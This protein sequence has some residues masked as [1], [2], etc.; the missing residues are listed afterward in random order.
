MSDIRTIRKRG[1]LIAIL[2]FL[3]GMV[4]VAR[5][6]QVQIIQHNRYAAYA[7]SQQKS[8]I[9]LKAKRGSIYDSQGKILAYDLESSTYT[10]SP[11]Y[12]SD[13]SRAARKLAKLTGKS[14]S[15]WL[16]EFE[17]H[18]GYLVVASKVSRGREAEFESA[19]IETLRRR[20]ETVRIYPYDGL[21]AEVIGRT[22]IDGVGVSGLEKYYDDLLS[23]EDGRSVYLRDAQGNEV[24]SWEH[25]IVDPMDGYD[26]HLS[27]DIDFQQIVTDEL[28]TMLD[29][30]GA[31]WGCAIFLDV[32]SGG[33]LASATL[34]RERP[35]FPR[36]RNI[37]DMNEPGSTSK[38]MPLVAVFQAGIF[39]PDDIINVERGR[40]NIGRRV[41]RDDHAYD[42][43]RCDEIGIYSS[44]IGVSKLGIEA[45][46][47]LIYRTLVQFG[48]GARTGIDFPG[49]SQ[50]ILKKPE[51]WNDHLLANICFGY[52]LAVTGVQIASAYGAI[53]SGGDLLKPYFALKAVSPDGKQMILNSR[54]VVRKVIDRRTTSIIHNILCDVVEIGTARKASD[55]LSLIAGK[56]GTALR[57]R[58]EGRG[59]DR[60]RSLASFAGYFPA[61]SPKVVG[62]VM[63]DEPQ[64]SIYGGEISAPVFKRIAIRYSSLPR[65][66]MMLNPGSRRVDWELME[67]R[68]GYDRADIL[69]ISDEPGLEAESYVAAEI[70]VLPDLRGN[71][72]REA[73]RK[74]KELGLEFE[75]IGSGIVK[76]QKPSPG[77]PMANVNTLQL[78]GGS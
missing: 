55:Q 21:G 7:D 48:F 46:P 16:K 45:G 51:T 6:V 64:T 49:E 39:E 19:A 76:S 41:I 53:A 50:G 70:T 65:N 60:T 13:K 25:T 15:R 23:G 24:T 34:E 59:Y 8:A 36:C 30:C 1:K 37:V 2:I 47:D 33:V 40:F 72:I 32:E 27:L 67:I 18:P 54:R 12:M 9:P 35:A 74:A 17:K 29:S 31:L 14:S 58:K 42:S 28:E 77:S 20:V 52:G 44:N 38:I 4:F 61:A 22:D 56:T 57:T 78:I 73:M 3:T 43:L 66:Y 62:V 5:A 71:T 11:G 63:F 68:T 69:P 10:V 75:V 26:I